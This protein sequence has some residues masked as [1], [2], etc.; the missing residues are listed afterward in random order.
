MQNKLQFTKTVS[1]KR[2]LLW[3]HSGDQQRLPEGSQFLCHKYTMS[4]GLP[5]QKQVDMEA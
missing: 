1:T 4:S 3:L 2:Y 5:R